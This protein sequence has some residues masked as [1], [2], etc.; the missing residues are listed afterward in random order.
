MST[1]GT[2]R[3]LKGLTLLLTLLLIGLG[4]YTY[5]FYKDVQLSEA[6]LEKER[7]QIREELDNEIAKYNEVL[8]QKNNLATELQ[9]AKERLE[10]LSQEVQKNKISQRVIDD[11]RVEL[12][13]LRNERVV[14]FTQNDSLIVVNE[15]LEILQEETKQSLDSIEKQRN[16]LLLENQALANQVA[17]ASL[18]TASNIQSRGV[19]QHTSGRLRVTQ[20]A[21]RTEMIHVRYE[22][23]E[24]DLA[25]EADLPFYTQVLDEK[26]NL[27][28][29]K[30][31]ISFSDGTTILFNTR[32]IVPYKKTRFSVSELI[33]PVQSF[34]SGT[35]TINVFLGSRLVLSDTLVLK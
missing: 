35:Y 22:I 25:I 3:I 20:R 28:G 4:I 29:T 11:Y 8:A 23:N 26:G 16:K 24:N 9:K 2:T 15:R 19:I 13:K 27:V 14:L 7:N 1:K 5:R 34:E 17:K 31:K 18:V 12:Q 32:T 33:L 21:K 6:Q 10:V 30:R